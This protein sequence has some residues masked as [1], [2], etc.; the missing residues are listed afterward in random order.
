MKGLRRLMQRML[1]SQL[2]AAFDQWCAWVEEKKK[3][4]TAAQRVMA[5]FLKADLTAAW[6]TWI[7]FMMEEQAT[8][9]KLRGL[10]TRMQQGSLAA[11]FRTWA[12][13][14][15]EAKQQTL[16]DGY[17]EK[18]RLAR[19]LALSLHLDRKGSQQGVA[20]LR[21]WQVYTAKA[22]RY[23]VILERRDEA[24]TRKLKKMAFGDWVR[25]LVQERLPTAGDNVEDLNEELIKD[26]KMFM[27]MLNLHRQNEAS[28]QHSASEARATVESLESELNSQRMLVEE[29][30]SRLAATESQLERDTGTIQSLSQRL[31][32]AEA[33][34]ADADAQTVATVEELKIVVGRKRAEQDAKDDAHAEAISGL[35]VEMRRLQQVS[36][37][38]E[39]RR[40][41]EVGAA[42]EAER[43]ATNALQIA[44]ERE[45]REV[46][47][48]REGLQQ[49]EEML[50][51]SRASDVVEAE[52]QRAFEHA[53]TMEEQ[54][55]R[56]ERK[57]SELTAGLNAL[58][59][60]HATLKAENADLKLV[61][62]TE[63]RA[64]SVLSTSRRD[65]N[66]EKSGLEEQVSSAHDILRDTQRQLRDSE[67]VRAA[68]VEQLERGR[69]SE[70]RAKTEAERAVLLESRVKQAQEL[71][72]MA[73][74]EK[75]AL[76]ANLNEAAS[77]LRTVKGSAEA[78]QAEIER[79]MSEQLVQVRMQVEAQT[80]VELDTMA[81]KNAELRR[82][83]AELTQNSASAMSMSRKAAEQAVGEVASGAAA[84]T[85]SLRAQLDEA[86]RAADLERAEASRQSRAKELAARAEHEQLMTKL[87]DTEQAAED[88]ETQVDALRGRVNTAEEELGLARNESA[89]ASARAE[90]AGAQLAQ[91][92]RD[93]DL[94]LSKLRAQ[95]HATQHVEGVRSDAV[96]ELVA[97]RGVLLRRTE[98]AEGQLAEERK[99][100][101]QTVADLEH[102]YER[103]RTVQEAEHQRHQEEANEAEERRQTLLARVAKL[104]SSTEERAAEIARLRNSNERT[105]VTG[106]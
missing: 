16:I 47:A 43:R 40:L 68:L 104:E 76:S 56:A 93:R 38:A 71:L 33:R 37:E 53:H 97:A 77:Q 88:A 29:R 20:A 24:R 58:K 5:R 14:I 23:S 42:R 63:Q 78:K 96:D 3:L 102:K 19:E 69:Q 55:G 95:L 100:W 72:T 27:Q 64:N 67:E 49:A 86:R 73:N 85:A 52:Y 30:S 35:Q 80:R 6:N 25:S 75:A 82:E 45:A 61:V 50:A 10:I 81:T 106:S 46:Q 101:E 83:L 99:L 11:A 32:V 84:T 7:D 15:R 48:L 105:K 60:Q 87:A 65:A 79:R 18:A 13:G 51:A 54:A 39:H 2:T 8:R 57:V 94:E 21:A 26:S 59:R 34:I 74:E 17:E 22:I 91:G 89:I 9:S 66:F 12:D 70:T 92:L 41:E 44:E 1:G 4:N 31:Q 28:L 98:E 36:D 90:H 62:A 103:Q